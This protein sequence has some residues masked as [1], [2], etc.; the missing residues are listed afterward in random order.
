MSQWEHEK[1][2]ERE[3]VSV[4]Y[5]LFPVLVTF[6]VQHQSSGFTSFNNLLIRKF[7]LHI[8]P[9]WLLSQS[10][11]FPAPL[12][13]RSWRW[14]RQ[15]G[16]QTLLVRSACLKELDAKGFFPGLCS[17]FKCEFSSCRFPYEL[18][19]KPNKPRNPFA[20]FRNL[21]TATGKQS[22]LSCPAGLGW[23]CCKMTPAAL[24]YP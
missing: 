11:V 16:H 17:N 10:R 4:R 24:Q 18:K 21:E 9:L 8:T 1:Q 5:Q 15:P 12:C 19:K 7:S 14:T 2:E 20:V 6:S 3:R 13:V 22:S 23:I